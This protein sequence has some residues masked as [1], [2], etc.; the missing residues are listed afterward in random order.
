[1][2]LAIAELGEIPAGRY[3]DL[4]WLCELLRFDGFYHADEKWTRDV[5]SRL[6]LAAGA[7][8]RITIGTSVTDPFTRHPAL[9]AQAAATL[10]EA[11][12]GRFHMIVGAGS[13]FETLPGYAVNRPAVAIRELIELSRRLW[14]GER[15]TFEGELVRYLGGKLDFGIDPAYAPKIWV[16]TRGPHV[17]RMAGEIADGVLMGSFATRWGIDYCRA[18]IEK[19]L[20]RAGRDWQDVALASWLYV[21]ILPDADAPVPEGVRR[22]VSHALWSSRAVIEP[23]LEELAELPDEFRR[24]MREAPHEWSPEVMAE[25]RGLIPRSVIDALSIVAT[26]DEVTD[27]LLALEEMGVQQAIIWPFPHDV[28]AGTKSADSSDIE[29][30]VV[31]LAEKVMP[32]VRRHESRGEYTLVD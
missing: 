1:M 28:T 17:L 30:F 25:L 21:S 18:E 15:V 10:A 23:L 24:F 22:G 3:T 4:V 12:R 26:A 7:T 31:T 19:G 13:H 5:W 2:K 14:A 16:A 29:D 27:R 11:T 6:G 32:R 8:S 9:T 20:H